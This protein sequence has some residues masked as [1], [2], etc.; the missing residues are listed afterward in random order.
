MSH[1]GPPPPDESPDRPD[2]QD[3]P[4]AT[5]SHAAPEPYNPY[6]EDWTTSRASNP[7][8]DIVAPPPS[9]Y[10]QGPAGYAGPPATAGPNPYG[11]PNQKRPTFAFGGF[12][13]W[14]TRVGAYLVDS[15]VTA[16]VG[17]PA[18]F[19]LVMLW[20]GRTTNETT[21]SS[22]AVVKTLELHPTATTSL[23]LFLGWVL[24]LGFTIW[25]SYIRQGNTGASIGKS[26]LAIRLVNA[27]F[28]PIGPGWAFLRQLLHVVDA[29]PCYLGYLN[30]IWDSRKQTFAD[31][32]M[33]TFV[34]H[35]TTQEPRP[36]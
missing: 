1:A 11:G 21:T 5:G 30:P 36:F 23:L 2:E 35:A 4:S 34:I 28:Q 20:N 31:K 24:S 8:Y 26:V 16:L 10:P 18:L 3:R 19:G 32:I 22:G 33:S 29:L 15:V 17:F 12:A 13:G 9:P 27:D 25:N 14:F 7:R 6:P